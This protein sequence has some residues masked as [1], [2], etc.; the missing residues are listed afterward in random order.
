MNEYPAWIQILFKRGSASSALASAFLVDITSKS[1]A[2][3]ADAHHNGRELLR[4]A[5]LEQ[6]SSDNIEQIAYSL[7]CLSV[8][9]LPQDLVKVELYVAHPS[10]LVCRAA[11]LCRFSLRQLSRNTPPPN[12]RWPAA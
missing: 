8:V 5:A 4:Q 7:A 2:N 1:I 10:D 12:G 9:G 11:K 3:E 6:L